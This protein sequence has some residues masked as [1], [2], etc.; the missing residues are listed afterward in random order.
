MRDNFNLIAQQLNNL[1]LFAEQN[2][3]IVT[4]ISGQLSKDFLEQT[5]Q[6]KTNGGYLILVAG[7]LKPMQPLRKTFETQDK[8]LA[9]A[10]YKEDETSIENFIRNELVKRE[11]KFEDGIPN[12][13]AANLPLNRDIISSEIEKIH[14]YIEKSL[15]SYELLNEVIIDIKEFSFDKLF[16]D[17][18]FAPDALENSIKKSFQNEQNFMGIIRTL[19]KQFARLEEILEI[20]LKN[21]ES[22]NQ[23][24][25]SLKPPIFFKVK[26]LF[27]KALSRIQLK[28]VR[29][30]IARLIDL[31]L[32]CKTQSF[33]Y[34]LLVSQRLL[35]LSYA[36][37]K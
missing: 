5:S 8:L 30:I 7:D 19:L 14:L 34:E 26:P 16:Y 32:Q 10:C 1:S 22:V 13:L 17:L 9:I 21:N 20:A 24:I 12:Y 31:E 27:V 3:I 28:T 6:L 18:I 4:N 2:I 23:A 29:K 11:I 25:D 35:E 37:K 33:N 36:L 15:L